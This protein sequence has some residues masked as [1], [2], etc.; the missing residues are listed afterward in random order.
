MRLIRLL[1]S[2]PQ[3]PHGVAEGSYG[4]LLILDT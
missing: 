1:G 2:A 3:L 4:S